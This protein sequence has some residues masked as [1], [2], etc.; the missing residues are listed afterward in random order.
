MATKS[1]SMALT[2]LAM[3]SSW[4]R[5]LPSPM[6][7]TLSSERHADYSWGWTVGWAA[8]G[9]HRPV[10]HANGRDPAEFHTG[11]FRRYGATRA[12]AADGGPAGVLGEG[13]PLQ[14]GDGEPGRRRSRR[15]CRGPTWQPPNS[16]G[17]TV[18]SSTR[19]TRRAGPR[20]VRLHVLEEAQLTA[21]AQHPTGLG[22]RAPPGRPSRAPARR[23]P[24]RP[25]RPASGSRVATASRS[26]TRS[27]AVGGR[28]LA[29]VGLGLDRDDPGDLVAGS[30]RSW[31]RRRRPPRP[32][33]FS[34]PGS[35]PQVVDRH[36]GDERRPRPAVEPRESGCTGTASTPPR[37][38]PSSSRSRGD[39][40]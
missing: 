26:S 7:R 14:L 1:S 30:A 32:V 3:A 8:D 20:L 16:R 12:I 24:R 2:A 6:R 13:E 39:N 35:P 9:A 10:N 19:W 11:G 27:S 18:A 23:R 40:R 5:I 22:Q 17:H 36:G 21:G 37:P 38:R 31:R 34:R 29:Q 4:R 15:R 25:R 33:P 28:L